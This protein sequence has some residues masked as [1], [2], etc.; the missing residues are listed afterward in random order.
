MMRQRIN[1]KRLASWQIDE[2]SAA[3]PLIDQALQKWL[4][5]AATWRRRFQAFESFVQSHERLPNKCKT[6]GQDERTLQVWMR[7]QLRDFAELSDE[8]L[9]LLINSHPTLGTQI[10]A[11]LE[12]LTS[13]DGA[14]SLRC[15]QLAMFLEV[16]NRLPRQPQFHA[17]STAHE[18]CLGGWLSL[19]RRAFAKLVPAQRREFATV[20]P[21]LADALQKLANPMS[22]FQSRC[23]ALHKFIQKNGRLPCVKDKDGSKQLAQWFLYQRGR[24]AANCV[25][26]DERRVLRHTHPMIADRVDGWQCPTFRWQNKCQALASYISDF[27]RPPRCATEDRRERLLYLWLGDQTRMCKAGLLSL[28]QLDQL[29]ALHEQIAARVESWQAARLSLNEVS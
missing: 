29:K 22:D 10:N 14:Y 24:F 8:K 9:D 7:N 27:G 12:Q 28:D 19:Q 4:D 6:A 17:K 20:H 3:N 2:L 1:L 18:R 15:D 26:Q 11:R 25:T 5:P 23:E 16:H 13:H 21:T